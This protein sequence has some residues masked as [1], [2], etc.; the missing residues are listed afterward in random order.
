MVG[1]RKETTMSKTTIDKEVKEQILKRVKDD[2]VPISQLAEEGLGE[3]C[4]NKISPS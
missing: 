1:V 3:E 4:I 2:G